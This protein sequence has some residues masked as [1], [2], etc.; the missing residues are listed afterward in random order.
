MRHRQAGAGYEGSRCAAV[1]APPLPFGALSA[2]EPLAVRA[3]TESG[4]L[5]HGEQSDGGQDGRDEPDH[6]LSSDSVAE[7]RA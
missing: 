5:G 7:L 3:L 6:A 1:R 4:T 2:R